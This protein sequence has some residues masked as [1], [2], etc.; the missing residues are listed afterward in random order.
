ML[1]KYNLKYNVVEIEFALNYIHVLYLKNVCFSLCY[2]IDWDFG[3][4]YGSL[5]QVQVELFRKQI[6]GGSKMS[7]FQYA[8]VLSRDKDK[9]ILL[10]NYF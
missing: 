9:G 4:L 1:F 8:M 5:E 6:C 3:Y 10:N 2:M 7:I